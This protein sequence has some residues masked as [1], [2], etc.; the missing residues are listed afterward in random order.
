M[1][2]V[3]CGGGGTLL[4]SP[5]RDRVPKDKIIPKPIKGATM[6]SGGRAYANRCQAPDDAYIGLPWGTVAQPYPN[7]AQPVSLHKAMFPS[8]HFEPYHTL[9]IFIG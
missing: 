3:Q 2:L 6:S 7:M 8:G 9:G 4:T 5:R 1:L